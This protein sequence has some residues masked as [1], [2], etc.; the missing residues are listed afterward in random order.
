MDSARKSTEMRGFTT[1]R[2]SLSYMENQKMRINGIYARSYRNET[3]DMPN[4]ATS[5]KLKTGQKHMD[6]HGR[7]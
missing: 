6:L 2:I 3:G 1:V 5:G 4:M 7:K